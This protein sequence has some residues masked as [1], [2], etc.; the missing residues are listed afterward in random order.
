MSW[1]LGAG[2]GFLR[3]GP[4]GA[5]LG[6]GIQHWVT[7]KLSRQ[8]NKNLP[9]IEDRGVFV[10]SLIVI[11]TKIALAKGPLT[12]QEVQIIYQFFIKNLNYKIADLLLINEIIAEARKL[13]PDMEPFVV[14]YRRSSQ[15]LYNQL[16]LALAYQIGLQSGVGEAS[17]EAID[18]LAQYLEVDTEAHQRMRNKYSLGEW[19]TPYTI[20]GVEVSASFEEIKKAY[21]KQAAE[22]HPDRVAHIGGDR[23]EEAHLK[24]LQIQSAY[25]ELER[26][27][28]S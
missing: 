15:N 5:I 23:A 1:L 12:S 25:E 18:Q 3:G 28:G 24:F 11:L 8:N 14:Q 6:G 26:L 22:F 4:I 27:K 10:T 17:Q 21:R 16:L 13:N 2:M 7:R 19:V 9:G 20:L